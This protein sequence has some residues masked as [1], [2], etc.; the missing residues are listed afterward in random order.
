MTKLID[1]T[2]CLLVFLAFI[3]FLSVFVSARFELRVNAETYN[4]IKRP[5]TWVQELAK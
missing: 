3:I 4:Y 1:S 5:A 2:I